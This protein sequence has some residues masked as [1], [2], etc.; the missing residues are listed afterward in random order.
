M[1]RENYLQS[2]RNPKTFNRS[3]IEKVLID[4]FSLHLS[5]ERSK[6]TKDAILQEGIKN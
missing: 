1:C 2:R 5:L 6:L 3:E 4:W